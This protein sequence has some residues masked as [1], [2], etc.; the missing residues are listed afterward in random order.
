MTSCC[1]VCLVSHSCTKSHI[2]LR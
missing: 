2:P 1:T